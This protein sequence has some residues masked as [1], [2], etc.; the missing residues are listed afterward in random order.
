MRH[1]HALA[2]E[3]Q[4]TFPEALAGALE[5][6][7]RIEERLLGDDPPC[8]CHNDLLAAN[9]I[10]DGAAVR[11][12]DWEYGG[13]GDRFF[14]LGNLAANNEFGHSHERSLLERYFGEVRPDHLRRLRLMRLVSDMREA[15]WGFAQAAISTLDIDYQAYARKHLRRYLDSPEARQ[16]GA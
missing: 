2:R 3:R 10:D 1:Y 11:L 6:L 7:A 8:P 4:V 9:F 14:D 15:M 12:I 13:M 16:F 5:R